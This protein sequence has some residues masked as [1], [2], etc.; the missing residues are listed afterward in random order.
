MLVDKAGEFGP[1]PLLKYPA[2]SPPVLSHGLLYVRGAGRLVCME[3]I[4]PAATSSCARSSSAQRAR[5]CTRAGALRFRTGQLRP[6]AVRRRRG[7]S[8]AAIR[9]STSARCPRP[10]ARRRSRRR[11][12]RAAAPRRFARSGKI[13][14]AQPLARLFAR[15]R[16]PA[17]AQMDDGDM[18]G[19][20]A[21]FVRAHR[22]S[23]P[24]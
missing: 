1:A 2:W 23:C 24:R 3:L 7:G 5:D 4:P 9:G 12:R 17:V 8:L 20:A 6:A 19:D 10:S 18:P 15:G 14:V 11:S 13:A 16:L 22:G 21:D